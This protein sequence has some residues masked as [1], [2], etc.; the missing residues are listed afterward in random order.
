MVLWKLKQ[1]LQDSLMN[2]KKNSVYLKYKC[3]ANYT[4]FTAARDPCNARLLNIIKKFFPKNF[5]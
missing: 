2:I 4:F 3:Y 5:V 1:F